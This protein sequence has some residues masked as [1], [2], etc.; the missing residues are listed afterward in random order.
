MGMLLM[1]NQ[2]F[3]IAIW[4]Q[5]TGLYLNFPTGGVAPTFLIAVLGG[6]VS[7][8]SPCVLPLV[9]AYVGYLGASC[10]DLGCEA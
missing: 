6:L 3:N 2:M 5:R 9:S 10:P 7:F 4:A 1:T 8:L